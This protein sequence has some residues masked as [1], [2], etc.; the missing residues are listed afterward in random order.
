MFLLFY[1]LLTYIDPQVFGLWGKYCCAKHLMDIFPNKKVVD[2][3]FFSGPIIKFPK[4]DTFAGPNEIGGIHTFSTS[5]T[6]TC[7]EPLRPVWG[8]IFLH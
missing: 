6:L 2:I 1:L 3:D 8:E 4:F 7:S 5:F